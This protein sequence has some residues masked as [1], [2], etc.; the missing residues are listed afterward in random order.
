MY[1]HLLVLSFGLNLLSTNIFAGDVKKGHLITQAVCTRCHVLPNSNKFGGIDS[2]LSFQGLRAL[3]DWRQ[4]FKTFFAR[5]PHLAFVQ[6]GE[7][8]LTNIPATYA[9]KIKLAPADIEHII[10]FVTTLS[11]R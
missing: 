3:P 7:G 8:Q 10:A 9:E 6:I 1:K 4:R 5:R 11:P 2:T